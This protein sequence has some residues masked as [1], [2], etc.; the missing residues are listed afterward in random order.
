MFLRNHWYVA[1][2]SDE[3]Q[4]EPLARTLLNE[5][6]VLYRTGSG[7]VAALE[8]CCSHRLMPLSKGRV[9]GETLVCCYHG[10]AFNSSGSCVHVPRLTSSPS[11]ALCVKSHP[12]AERYG[13]IW[14]WMGDPKLADESKILDCS[15]LDPTGSDGTRV[16]FY[17]KANYL[18]ISDNL[19][20]LLHVGFLHNPSQKTGTS[21]V[22][23][24][25]IGNDELA[26]GKLD[27]RQEG[28]RIYGD[29]TWANITPPTTFKTL[30][31]I[32]ER[33]DGWI[34][35]MF[36]PPSFFVNPIGFAEAGTGGRGSTL[37]QGSGKFSFT[38][39]QCITPETDRSTHFF[40]L[41]AHNWTPEMVEKGIQLINKVNAEDI[42]AMECQQETLDHNPHAQMRYI[43]TDGAVVRMHRLL[44]KLIEEEAGVGT[45][46]DSR[47]HQET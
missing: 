13:A 45:K 46:A 21:G 27:V 2:F 12:V 16:Y 35:S 10:L 25:A 15:L 17:V 36:H 29:W 42:W 11:S 1:G 6:V 33:A 40:K 44:D 23:N 14:L 43:P 39:Y 47:D 31:G 4:K 3:V 41:L 38:I 18:F 9:D 24:S 28:E 34:M 8:D 30:A 37:D 32:Q 7:K 20:D 22:G 5:R 19:A 26:N